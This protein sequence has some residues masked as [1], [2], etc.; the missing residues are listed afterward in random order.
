M[1]YQV[2]I[3][4]QLKKIGYD[5]HIEVE[6]AKGRRIDVLAIKNGRRVGVEV[7]LNA[8]VDL[9][10]KL[11]GIESL[12]ELYIVT[13]KKLFNE[14]REKL[15]DLPS[16]VRLYSIDRF[17][18]VFGNLAREEM[19]NNSSGENQLRASFSGENQQSPSL[20]R[21]EKLGGKGIG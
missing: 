14:V 2:L 15:G 4:W 3:R 8:N 18:E 19:G 21:K 12:D 10:K 5:A 11:N 7:E 1:L 9:K 16:N 6:I 20:S 13:S 17:L